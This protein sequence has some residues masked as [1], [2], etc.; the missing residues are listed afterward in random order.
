M[1][2]RMLGSV[3]R[4]APR[5]RHWSRGLFGTAVAIAIVLGTAVDLPLMAVQDFAALADTAMAAV[6]PSIKFDYIG[7]NQSWIVP[8]GVTE[9]SYIVY[10]AGGGTGRAPGIGMIPGGSGA[11]IVGGMP[12]T[13]GET[14]TI[15]VGGAGAPGTAT[16]GGA[17][18]FGG[19]GSGGNQGAGGGGGASV[20]R[21]GSTALVVAAG[22]GG[23]GG[24]GD[25]KQGGGGGDAPNS[26]SSVLECG[27]DVSGSGGGAGAGG[28]VGGPGAVT[29]GGL[30]AASAGGG[31]Q[32]G[33]GGTGGKA[34]DGDGTGMRAGGGGGGGGGVLGGG[35]GGG[36]TLNA[37]GGACGTLGAGGGG[38]SGSSLV[39]PGDV[40]LLPSSSSGNGSVTILPGPSAPL[41][42]SEV[43]FVN[44][45]N[46]MA[47]EIYNPGSSP[48]ILNDRYWLEVQG[49]Y[50]YLDG[51]VNPG[52]VWVVAW[53]AAGPLTLLADQHS[54]ASA[55]TFNQAAI[56]L[57]AGASVLDAINVNTPFPD[58]CTA[59]VRRR[60]EINAGFTGGK[61]FVCDDQ[62]ESYPAGTYDG[63]G[64]HLPPLSVAD[65]SATESTNSVTT[66]HVPVTLARPSPLTVS[67]HYA[68][69]P[70]SALATADF[71]PAAGTLTFVPGETAKNVDIPVTSDHA[72]EVGEQLT[73]VLSNAVNA[74]IADGTGTATIL[75]DDPLP[76][77]TAVADSAST[78]TGVAVDVDV[79][80]NDTAT[81]G[82]LAAPEVLASPVHGTATATGGA[83]RYTSTVGFTGIDQLT[84]RVCSAWTP[85]VCGSA[86]VDVSVS[87]EIVGLVPARL[88]DTRSDG[89]T[90]DGR[91][92]AN[93]ERAAGSITELS[94]AGR[95]GV[96]ADA[97]AV[98][99]NVTATEVRGPGF[100]TVWPCGSKQPLASSLNVSAGQTV[101]NAVVARIG[102]G[103]NVCL[104]TLSATHLVVDVNAY[105]PKT[106]AYVPMVPARFLDS[107]PGEPTVDGAFAGGGTRAGG[108]IT[109]L[110]VAGRAGVPND[111][112][113]VVLNVTATAV[114]GAGFVTVWPCGSERPVASNLNVVGGQTVPN[115][116]VTKVGSGGRVCLFT[117]SA[118]DLIVD[119]N[120]YFPATSTFTPIVP[121]RLLDTRPGEPTID[122]D[123]AG[124]GLR[125]GGSVT[126]LVVGGRDKVPAGATTVAMNVTAT[127]VR[128][129]GFVTVWPC[130]SKQPLASN[131]N[132]VAG[133]TVP[134]AVIARLG[135]GG[136]ICLFTLS[137][138]H[139]IVDVTGYFM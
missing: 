65:A 70:G 71:T 18:G 55:T 133:A 134:N 86:T 79:R 90:V 75:D 127:D 4:R 97:S 51:V 125:L 88:L 113:A 50:I 135:S 42:I 109:E 93:G 30:F 17:G 72:H 36:G 41:F 38:G 34:Y 80:A 32:P 108:S 84:Y 39:P 92:A 117:L 128:G 107:R 114:H 82:E 73:V 29:G 89:K 77:V 23:T 99:L 31:G 25:V 54:H 103:G 28:G 95:G 13:P 98:V 11:A 16:L 66:L 57:R 126:E 118:L 96:P 83:I 7:S 33:L 67:V 48:V 21:R 136:T 100:V 12:V 91:F 101:A 62:Y 35:G 85:T 81:V 9:V 15:I 6:A 40:L 137:D 112:A 78:A 49:T 130:G 139:L 138:A 43:A 68:T 94:V 115:L 19:G 8:A 58:L 20:I 122:G 69:T 110:S 47:V 64:S 102:T 5:A 87:P 106:S 105:F 121:A 61:P 132:V 22:G 2:T 104:F 52:D 129:P 26:G 123:F 111:A 124:D 10:G 46:E 60:P 37:A 45:P 59:P 53:G 119:V 76:V 56:R 24:S 63:I 14:L 27:G 131:L 116:V 44:S 120:G 3:R 1:T 74:V